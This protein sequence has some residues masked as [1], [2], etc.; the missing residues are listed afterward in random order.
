M[1]VTCGKPCP[2]PHFSVLQGLRLNLL[3]HDTR[4]VFGD[5]ISIYDIQDAVSDHATVPIYYESR[6]AK[7]DIDRKKIEELNR[8]AEEVLE[9]D[10]IEQRENTKS[11]WA[12]LVK[13]VGAKARLKELAADLVTHYEK[14]T[15]TFIG[16]AMIVCMSRQICSGPLQRNHCIVSGVAPMSRKKEASKSL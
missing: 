3:D 14:R 9:E 15:E 13:L 7:L 10:E 4:A 1:P 5:Y 6:L 11:K 8:E 2:M 16:K 12:Q